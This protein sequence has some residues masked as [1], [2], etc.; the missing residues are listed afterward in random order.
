MK[1]V[2][3]TVSTNPTSGLMRGKVSP[4]L[5]SIVLDY[6]EGDPSKIR[7]YRTHKNGGF[8]LSYGGGYDVIDADLLGGNGDGAEMRK[9]EIA[10]GIGYIG[11]A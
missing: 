4:E 7:A 8:G 9:F 10:T 5:A 2:I 3:K 11:I 1:H 6:L